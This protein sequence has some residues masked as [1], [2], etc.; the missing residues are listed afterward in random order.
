MKEKE[1]GRGSESNAE[2]REES[3]QFPNKDLVVDAIESLGYIARS[4]SCCL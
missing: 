1:G 2:E 3:Y 4:F